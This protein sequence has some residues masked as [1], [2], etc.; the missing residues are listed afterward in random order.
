[1]NDAVNYEPYRRSD[2]DPANIETK[3]LQLAIPEY[4]NPTQWR[5]INRAIIYGK[6]NGVSIVI[7]RI[8]E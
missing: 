7:T 2:L 6:E 1:M 8:R 3:T 5:Y 4:T